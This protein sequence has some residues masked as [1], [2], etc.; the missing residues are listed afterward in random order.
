M[1]SQMV[2]I[3]YEPLKRIVIRELVKYDSPLQLVNAL[4]FIMKMG[5]P[6]L[7][8]WADSMVFVSQPIPP[9]DMPEEYARG[10][11]YIASISYAPMAEFVHNVK[12]GNIEM[13]VIDVSR[14]PL[15]Q[16]LARFLKT[17]IEDA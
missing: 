12:S 6:V 7:L 13:P 3:A 9:S 15:S 16:E 10:E 11:L 1:S 4:S 8:T 17:K 2:E 5:Q 14:S